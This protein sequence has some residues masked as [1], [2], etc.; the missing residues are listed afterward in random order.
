[1]G[2]EHNQISIYRGA[3][4]RSSIPSSYPHHDQSPG[5]LST[6]DVLPS[7]SFSGSH[8][9]CQ[10]QRDSFSVASASLH[11]VE[12]R[13]HGKHLDIRVLSGSFFSFIARA[14]FV[15]HFR[16]TVFRVYAMLITV[17]SLIYQLPFPPSAFRP[18]STSPTSTHSFLSY[19]VF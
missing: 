9:T 13:S 6:D 15:N 19:T 4:D 8:L 3:T 7:L 14:L 10:G 5:A 2:A 18:P 1:M 12:T 17:V 11:H 16:A